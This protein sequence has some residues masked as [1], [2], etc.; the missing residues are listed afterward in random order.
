MKIG[1]KMKTDNK[2]KREAV[3]IAADLINRLAHTYGTDD[4]GSLPNMAWAQLAREFLAHPDGQAAEQRR[5]DRF[6]GRIR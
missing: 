6:W 1:G 2:T 4:M 3:D 5:K